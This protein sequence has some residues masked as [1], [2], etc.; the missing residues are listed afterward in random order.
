MSHPTDILTSFVRLR[1]LRLLV[2]K[3][4]LG[5]SV[6]GGNVK[7]RARVDHVLRQG[8]LDRQLLEA[9]VQLLPIGQQHGVQFGD[10][11]EEFD[12]IDTCLIEYAFSVITHFIRL[13]RSGQQSKD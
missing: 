5:G 3:N 9:T 2:P 8:R 10:L 7:Q 11:H 4:G 6:D 13:T 12:S 1:L